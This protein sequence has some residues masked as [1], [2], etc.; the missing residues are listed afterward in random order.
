MFA[1]WKGDG[2]IVRD[3]SLTHRIIQMKLLTLFVVSSFVATSSFFGGAAQAITTPWT[4]CAFKHSGQP[5][6]SIDCRFN[7]L[8]KGWVQVQWADG[9]SD[10]FEKVRDRLIK[11]T[12]G[13]LWIV[14]KDIYKGSQML[15]FKSISSESVFVVP[16]W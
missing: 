10:T 15:V 1:C 7:Q 5:V 4:D 6:K 9:A 16:E 8:A 11:D 13:G 14:E 2:V 12:R 3:G